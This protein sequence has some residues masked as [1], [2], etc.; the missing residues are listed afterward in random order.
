MKE[1]DNKFFNI[2]L[3]IDKPMFLFGRAERERE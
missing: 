2:M 3:M 1:K